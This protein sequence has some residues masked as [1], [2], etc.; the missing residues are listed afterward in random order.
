MPQNYQD[1]P[2]TTSLSASRP[3]LLDRD[4]AVASS[5]SG[6]AFPTANLFVGMRCHR[7]DLNKIYVLKDLTPTWIEVED[8]AG[9]SGL[10]PRATALATAQNFSVSGDVATASA[11]SFNGTAGVTLNV[12][13]PALAGLSAG[14]YTKVTVNAKG[15]VT[16]GTTLSSADFPAD[17][18]TTTLRMTGTGLASLASTAHALQIGPDAGANLI[19]DQNEIQA[20]NAGA[21][22]LLGLNVNGGNVTIGNAA[23]TT[24]IAGSLNV[25][26][27]LALPANS[28]LSADINAGAVTTAKIADGAVTTA[29]LAAGAAAADAANVTYSGIGA[30]LLGGCNNAVTTGPGS[31]VAG[32][33]ITAVGFAYSGGG[34]TIG[35]ISFNGTARS[36]TWR[37]MGHSPGS[38][39]TNGFGGVTLFLRIA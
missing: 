34:T 11:V 30:Y 36:G 1:I 32:S 16:A 12:S 21:A 14:T 15:Q 18:S 10:A 7:T 24:T 20:R 17:L 37:A 35:G 25:T 4:A 33:T 5:F 27:G 26:T 9:A 3:L 8:V 13:L 28:V 29:K 38:G 19:A 23:S 2:A 22:A 31:T 39:G 6:T